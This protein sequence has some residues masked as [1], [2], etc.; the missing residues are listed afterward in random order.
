MTYSMR[1]ASQ[2]AVY[3]TPHPQ[4]KHLFTP[5]ESHNSLN[6]LHF[7][8]KD[9]SFYL[10]KHFSTFFFKQISTHVIKPQKA[11]RGIKAS[12]LSSFSL[13]D[14]QFLSLEKTTDSGFL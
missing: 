4:R 5:M 14:I 9:T 3:S 7:F 1:T 11:Q 12:L 8:L 6:S 10:F 2:H 13:L